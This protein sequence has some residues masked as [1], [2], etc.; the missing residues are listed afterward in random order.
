M[1]KNCYRLQP[2]RGYWMRSEPMSAERAR[3]A[4]HSNGEVFIVAGGSDAAGTVT[5]TVEQFDGMAWTSLSTMPASTE[6]Q[7][8]IEYFLQTYYIIL[9]IKEL[10]WSI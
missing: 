4:S 9:P 10:A 8:L 2:E 5:N 7:V 3:A 1:T 6:G